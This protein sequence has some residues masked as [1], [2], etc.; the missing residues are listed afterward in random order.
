[1]KL[2][3]VAPPILACMLGRIESAQV[4]GENHLSLPPSSLRLSGLGRS[5]YAERHTVLS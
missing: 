4:A 1:M 2:Q 3:R 5:A